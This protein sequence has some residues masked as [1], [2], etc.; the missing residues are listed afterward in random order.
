MIT[1]SNFDEE[2]LKSP[3]PFLLLAWAPW[4]PTCRT[5][6]PVV[7]DYARGVKGKVRVGKANV[8]GSPALSSKFNIL[9][10]P[11]LFVFDKGQLKENMPGAMQKAEIMMKM[12]RHL[13]S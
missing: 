2:V 8:D 3:L 12:S 1:D 11:Q 5:F 7:D 6:L 13:L 9:S 4:C 10:V